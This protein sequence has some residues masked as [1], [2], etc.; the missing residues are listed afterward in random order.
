MDVDHSFMNWFIA[1]FG[2]W[3]VLHFWDAPTSSVVLLHPTA[4]YVQ[5]GA[6]IARYT[7][8][9][10]HAETAISSLVLPRQVQ[11]DTR[12]GAQSLGGA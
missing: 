2:A 12:E 4:V 1:H 10:I 11:D 7:V 3:M 5:P 9:I 8:Y 6:T